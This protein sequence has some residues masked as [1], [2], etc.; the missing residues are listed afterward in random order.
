MAPPILNMTLTGETTTSINGVVTD[1]QVLQ[2]IKAV[3]R[4][5]TDRAHIDV[6]PEPAA[7]EPK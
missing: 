2:Q 4:H 5:V 7:E 3:M 6:K 1:P